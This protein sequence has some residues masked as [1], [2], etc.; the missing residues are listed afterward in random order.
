MSMLDV[1][2][3]G[4]TTATPEPVGVAVATGGLPVDASAGTDEPIPLAATRAAGS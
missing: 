2:L 1:R 3:G 4:R